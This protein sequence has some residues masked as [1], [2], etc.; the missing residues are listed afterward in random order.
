[1]CR[2]NSI[3]QW[4]KSRICA[5]TTL[6]EEMR[7]VFQT[8]DVLMLPTGN[9]APKLDAEIVGTDA[10][11]DPPSPPRPDVFN[12]TN[13]TE[14]TALVLPCGFTAGAPTLLLGIQYCAN[15]FGEATFFRIGHAYQRV[16]RAAC[17]NLQ[18][19]I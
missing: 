19:L 11:S 15:P 2:V 12:I 6:M 17:P 10:P 1:M 7:R 16:S 8:C 5:S 14:I 18:G 3:R 13:V 9:A 4:T